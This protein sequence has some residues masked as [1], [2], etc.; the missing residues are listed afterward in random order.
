MG[1]QVWRDISLIFLI[2]QALLLSLVPLAIVGGMAYGMYRLHAVVRRLFA[3]VRS[4]V[5]IVH[6]QVER[7]SA[8]VAAPLISA[9]AMAARVGA[10]KRFVAKEL[11]R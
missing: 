7:A 1:I 10:W 5:A 11:T 9:H 3:R 4:I 2:V 6:M 8:T